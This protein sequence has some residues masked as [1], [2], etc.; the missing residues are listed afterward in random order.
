MMSRWRIV[1]ASALV[2]VALCAWPAMQSSVR[3]LEQQPIRIYVSDRPR[4]VAEAVAQVEAATGV[5]VTYE[6]TRYVYSG[7]IID[8]A[9]RLAPSRHV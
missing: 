1:H 7:G 8:S 2:A 6:D 4:P 9:D 3:G 5:V